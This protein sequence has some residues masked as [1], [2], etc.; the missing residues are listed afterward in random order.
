[1]K[2]FPY[3]IS[4]VI[5]SVS[6]AYAADK[7]G[8]FIR[9]GGVGGVNCSTFISVMTQAQLDGG[10]TSLGGADKINP[11]ANYITGFQTGYNL[12][13][14]TTHDIF[15]KVGGASPTNKALFWIEDWCRNNPQELF[16]EAVI[17]LAKSQL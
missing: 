10:L 8:N 3:I 12:A 9:G 11:Y 14:P 1:M 16:G 13:H 17:A 15:K 5:F 4:I 2:I 6:N 7:E